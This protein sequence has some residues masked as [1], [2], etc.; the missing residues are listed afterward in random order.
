MSLTANLKSETMSLIA[1]SETVS[2]IANSE[3]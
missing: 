2:L 1:N 3:I